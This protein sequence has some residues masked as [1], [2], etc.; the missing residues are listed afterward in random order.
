MKIVS[1]ENVKPG[2]I[3]ARPLYDETMRL[4][5]NKGVVVTQSLIIKLGQRGHSYIYLQAEGT[6]EIEIEDT[7][8]VSVSKKTADDL[9]AIFKL[10]RNLSPKEKQ[11]IEEHTDKI[12]LRGKFHILAKH[13]LFRRNT[14]KIVDS[15]LLLKTPII[16]SF[17]LSMLSAN[18]IS[19]AMDTAILSILLGL[20]FGYSRKELY[21]L[22]AA[23]LLHDC[24]M[25][26]MV[27]LAEKKYFQMDTEELESY[28]DHP[29]LGYSFLDYLN[30]FLPLETQTVLQHHENQ[31]G[32]GFPSALTGTNSKPTIEQRRERGQIFRMAEIVSVADR[33]IRYCSGEFSEIPKNPVEAVSCLKAESGTLLNSKI[34]DEFGKIVN[35]F[36]TG[37]IIR[38]QKSDDPSII[39]FEGVVRNENYREMGKPV[40][41]LLRS[42]LGEKIKPK[43]VNMSNDSSGKIELLFIL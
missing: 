37:A 5:V 13:G 39:G 24:G 6:E 29:R 20:R 12:G 21:E 19:H 31:D 41:I 17:S 4:L 40:V 38:I 3:I 1:L 10:I 43:V 8:P 18:P 32:T 25:L 11:S 26:F 14:A 35:L 16:S 30:S 23:A 27:E 42:N 36:P 28:K 33:Y 7:I 22:A 2:A 34:V 15:L 9:S